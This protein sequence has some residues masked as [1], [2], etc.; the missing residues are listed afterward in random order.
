V[1]VICYARQREYKPVRPITSGKYSA[2]SVI[3][4]E[5]SITQGLFAR[6]FQG[7]EPD[8]LDGYGGGLV[9]LE[10]AATF[11]LTDIDP[12]GSFITGSRKTLGFDKGFQEHR[13]SATMLPVEAELK[14]LRRTSAER[15]GSS[16]NTTVE[17]ERKTHLYYFH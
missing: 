4:K 11:G 10:P 8:I 9:N 14:W 13:R 16:L 12:V 1:I 7:V 15:L 2:N 6:V 17:G 5:S 3:A